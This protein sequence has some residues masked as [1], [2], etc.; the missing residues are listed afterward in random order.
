VLGKMSEKSLK[1]KTAFKYPFNNAARMLYILWIIGP[2]MI[3]LLGILSIK[4]GMPEE[5][6]FILIPI[7]IIAFIISSFLLFGYGIIIIKHF[8]KGDFSELPELEFGKHLKLGFFMFLKFIPFIIIMSII[9][10]LL[11][12]IPLIGVL[13]S[14]FVS[15]FVAPIL[16]INFFNKET[17]E[18]YFEFEIIR[19]VFE[20]FEEYIIAL[21][22]SLALAVIFF[23]MM[24]ILV[25]IPARS[26]TQNIFIADFYR[27]FVKK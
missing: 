12:F 3:L 23:L 24:I 19:C 22:K 1:F 11:V 18:S 2:V 6:L 10:I 25:G 20:D 5:L 16:V 4:L 8:I 13:A 21:L 27:R 7:G 15:L 14:W 26:F 9:N 17:I